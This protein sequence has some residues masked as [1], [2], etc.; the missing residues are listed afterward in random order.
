MMKR[1][2]SKRAADKPIPEP[3]EGRKV[4]AAAFQELR[5]EGLTLEQIGERFNITRQRVHQIL[6][7]GKRIMTGLRPGTKP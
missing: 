7:K 2:S 3:L 4:R 5:K 1:A 6:K